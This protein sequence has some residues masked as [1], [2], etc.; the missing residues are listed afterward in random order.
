MGAKEGVAGPGD[1]ATGA[2]E[3]LRRYN[4]GSSIALDRRSVARY[5]LVSERGFRVVQPDGGPP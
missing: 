5:L 3:Y 1:G 4:P 2:A